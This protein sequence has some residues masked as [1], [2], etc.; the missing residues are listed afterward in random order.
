MVFLGMGVR[1]SC[2]EVPFLLLSRVKAFT[3]CIGSVLCW[4][5]AQ[6]ASVQGHAAQIL[7][8]IADATYDQQKYKCFSI[9]GGPSPE[10]CSRCAADQAELV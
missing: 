1:C 8:Q 3:L 2:C 5:A 6:C 9:M 10:E 4:G 7:L